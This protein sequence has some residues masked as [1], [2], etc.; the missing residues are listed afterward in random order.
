MK[1]IASSSTVGQRNLNVSERMVKSRRYLT[2]YG[3][4]LLPCSRQPPV[5][6]VIRGVA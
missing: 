3:G 5:P 4:G 2:G 1:V 6:D